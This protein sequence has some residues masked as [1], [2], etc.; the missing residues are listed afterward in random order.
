MLRTVLAIVASY[1]VMVVIILA[2]FAGMLFGLGINFLLEPGTFNGGRFLTIAAPSITLGAGLFGGWLCRRVAQRASAVAMLAAVVFV[3]GAI[4]AYSTLQKPFPTGPRDP[5][6]SLE[7]FMK[8]GR[9]P[10]WLLLL[11]PPLGAAAVLSGGLLLPRRKPT[12]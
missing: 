11:N 4:T 6:L 3:L 2:L 9:E 8:V 10:T 1:V 12:A 7:E 5:N